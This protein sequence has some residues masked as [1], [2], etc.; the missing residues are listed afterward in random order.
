MP[1]R[2]VMQAL[3]PPTDAQPQ[4]CACEDD[5]AVQYRVLTL[6]AKEV[7]WITAPVAREY[8]LTIV[9]NGQELVTLLCSPGEERHLVLGFLASEGIIT[10]AVEVTKI[11]FDT[12]HGFV[13]VEST[14]TKPPV[15]DALLKR[16]LTACCSRGRAGLCF[17]NDGDLVHTVKSGV[18][19]SQEAIAHYSKTLDALSVTYRATGGVHGGALF[20]E[21][22][23][24][25][26][27]Q[28]MGRH[29]VLDKLYGYC[30]DHGI[31]MQDMIL[32]FSGRVSTEVLLKVNK[33][34]IPVIV[35]QGAPSTQALELA[36]KL[37][38]TII[39]FARE[40]SCSVYTHAE[41]IC[42]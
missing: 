16:C 36:E 21:N 11:T 42:T 2:V 33:M 27:S 14:S 37:H 25:C 31:A 13:W 32:S 15:G 30:L 6:N 8:S 7:D 28:D 1:G 40:D 18:R 20:K 35:A 12:D 38:I 39:G 10:K 5:A 26:F 24:L 29:N 17:A 19:L 4:E 23:M 41:R 3:S 9:H 22:E 34:N